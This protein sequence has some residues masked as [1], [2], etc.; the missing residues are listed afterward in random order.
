MITSLDHMLAATRSKL[1]ELRADHNGRS[2]VLVGFNTGAALACQVAL[3]ENVTSVVCI[4]FP[5][6][7]VEG[8]RGLPDDN[9]LNLSVPVLFIAGEHGTNSNKD[10]LEDLRERLRVESGL[11]IVGSADD[12]LRVSKSTLYTEGVTQSMVDHC[13]VVSIK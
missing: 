8:K 5:L 2:I 3:L 4:G 6:N 13:I 10:D 1:A 7:T 11:V 9:I 12:Q